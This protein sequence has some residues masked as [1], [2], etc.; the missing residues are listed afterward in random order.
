M[1]SLNTQAETGKPRTH[2]APPHGREEAQQTAE[3]SRAE[4]RAHGGYVLRAR[5]G[6]PAG[7]G[8]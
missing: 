5:V 4:Q 6:A 3:Q 1:F 2:A 8:L 7:F